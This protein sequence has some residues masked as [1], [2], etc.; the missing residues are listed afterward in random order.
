MFTQLV[1]LVGQCR[2]PTEALAAARRAMEQHHPANVCT[3]STFWMRFL[4]LIFLQAVK[5]ELESESWRRQ[6][7]TAYTQG[8]PEQALVAYT[9]VDTLGWYADTGFD[10]VET[11]G[12]VL[13]SS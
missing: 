11:T 3:Y 5:S 6:G 8:R 1:E 4:C 12:A 13:G 9:K 7:N 10:E 2:G